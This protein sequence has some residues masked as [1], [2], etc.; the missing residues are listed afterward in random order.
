MLNEKNKLDSTGMERHDAFKWP[1]TWA[2]RHCI[3]VVSC[4]V[5]RRLFISLA[6]SVC[7][8]SETFGWRQWKVHVYARECNSL[9]PNR[10]F[11]MFRMLFLIGWIVTTWYGHGQRCNLCGHRN[12]FIFRLQ[13]MRKC[14]ELNFDLSLFLSIQI[15][16]P[17]HSRSLFHSL[18]PVVTRSSSYLCE[19]ARI[20]SEQCDDW[21]K[22]KEIE[23]KHVRWKS[24]KMKKK[25]LQFP[26]IKFHAC[27]MLLHQWVDRLPTTNGQNSFVNLWFIAF[28]TTQS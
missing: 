1:A 17:C 21:E 16:G 13:Q 20:T 5:I 23:W 10:M 3:V 22:G 8:V 24:L 7:S 18:L 6:N 9:Q 26:H 2:I 12:V 15:S 25:E 11:R 14:I 27:G 4:C 28:T 19:R